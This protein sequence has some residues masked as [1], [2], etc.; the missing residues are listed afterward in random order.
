MKI[1]PADFNYLV[2]QALTSSHVASMRPV[3]EKELLHYDILFCLDQAGL[4]DELVFQGGTSLRL[5][6]GGNRF[7]E[8]LDFAGGTDF[9]SAKLKT[10][11]QCI[12]DYIG[13]RYGLEVSVKEPNRLKQ[14]PEYAELKIDKWQIFIITAPDRKDIP[15]QR[16][17]IE[18]A[19]IPAY[20]RSALP[21]LKNYDFLPDG[22]EDTLVYV[23]TLNEIMAD[24]LVSLP[25]TRRYIRYRDIWD[26]VWL[27]Q[28]GAGLDSTL[29]AKKVAD[30]RMND[31]EQALEQRLSSL[32]GILAE[33]KLQTEMKRFIPTAVYERTLGKEKFSGYLNSSLFKLLGQL[34]AELYGNPKDNHEFIL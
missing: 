15:K 3:I 29:V 5:C 33:G 26:L 27:Q 24:K 4:L 19:N 8:D 28:Q 2:E 34:K 25:A 20:T 32:S 30:Y 31:F 16:I 9:S 13:K 14:E 22:Y 17:K 23:E 21:L 6:Y 10:I 18:V 1:N 11:K 7:S 12:E